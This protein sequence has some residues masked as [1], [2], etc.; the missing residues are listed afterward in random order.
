MKKQIR[1]LLSFGTP[2]LVF[3]ACFLRAD[4]TSRS[5]I[6]YKTIVG[7]WTGFVQLEDGKNR[8]L[9]VVEFKT[10]NACR[11]ISTPLPK[12]IFAHEV[13]ASISYE[14]RYV[15]S[16][17]VVLI[18]R[19]LSTNEDMFAVRDNNILQLCVNGASG[20]PTLL[21]QV[22]GTSTTNNVAPPAARS[23]PL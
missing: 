9:L 15:V 11:F 21:R 22:A 3:F 23:A 7:C 5:T 12:E 6:A 2:V 10:N 13:P 4:D 18:W 20:E 19:G 16:N 14:G 17:D 8:C 1:F